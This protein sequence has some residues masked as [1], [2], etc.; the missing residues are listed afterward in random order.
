MSNWMAIISILSLTSWSPFSAISSD[1]VAKIKRTER[2]VFP[3]NEALDFETELSKRNVELV[4]V[5]EIEPAASQLKLVAYLVV[6]RVYN[7]ALLH[8][9]CVAEEYRRRGIATQLLGFQIEKLRRS[10]CVKI[11]LWV[12]EQREAARTLYGKVGFTEVD[13]VVNYYASERAGIKMVL[14]L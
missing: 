14:P 10:K 6:T 13:R 11:Q 3:R 5:V 9:L 4:A 8:K 12:D 2:K 1:V 7:I